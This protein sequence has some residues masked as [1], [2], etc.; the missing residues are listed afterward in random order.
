MKRKLNS[1]YLTRGAAVAA[2]YIALTYLSAMLGLSSGVIQ[3]R[4][5]EALCILPIF[6]PEATLGLFIGCIISNLI[7]SAVIWDVIFGSLAT[8]IGAVG[9][10]A[11]KRL[12]P[13]F[14]WCA[15]LPT[16]IANA[17]IIPP[18]LIFAYGVTD[19]YWFIVT[20]VGIG[21]ILSATVCGTAL[22]FALKRVRF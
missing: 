17:L 15:T 13:R 3:L 7:T 5:S 11:L 9:A 22:Y 20:T 12:P 4:I 16:V 10:L 18:V 14:I 1:L 21:E 6:M 19:A 8:L 2:C